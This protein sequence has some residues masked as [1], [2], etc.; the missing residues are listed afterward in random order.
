[1]PP[2]HDGPRMSTPAAISPAQVMARLRDPE[3]PEWAFLDLREVGDAAEGHPFASVRAP[4]S[5]LELVI[6]RLVPRRATPIVL[7]D[8]GDGVA[9]RAADRLVAA[10]WC[11]IAIVAG[12]IP[13]WQAAGLPL[14]KGV[15]TFSKAFGEWVQHAFD[16]PEIGPEDLAARMVGP[17]PPALID[18]RPTPEHCAFT[19]PG[20]RGCPNAELPLRLP[21]ALAPDTP[22]VVVHCAGRTRSIIGAQTLRD[23]GLPLRVL[24]LRDGTQGWELSGRARAV[25]TGRPIPLPDAAAT[26]EARTQAEAVIAR[27]GLPLIAP[28]ALSALL[29]EGQRTVYLLDPRAEDAPPPPPG[30]HRA[31]G[32]TLIQQTEQFVAVRGAIAVLWDPDL[33]RAVFAALWL[34]RMGIDARILTA[35]PPTIA[36]IPQPMPPAAVAGLDLAGLT[37][38]LARGAAVLDMRPAAAFHACHIAGARRGLRAELP[39]LGL[40]AAAPVVLIGDPDDGRARLIAADLAAAGHP[41]CGISPTGPADWAAA[42]LATAPSGEDHAPDPDVVR[43]CAGRH[44]GNLDDARAYLAWETGLLDRLAAAGLA[45]WPAP[46]YRPQTS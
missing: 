14:F 19:L 20:A 36:P 42:G 41:V 44:S 11:D 7:I 40:P 33:L 32:T 43:F 13:G 23:F 30:F 35:A 24:A 46:T 29:A 10:G 45:P 9:A 37:A 26:A 16:V 3:A 39:R 25:G 6:A 4:F 8:A 2:L 34:R 22:E 5:G 17:T 15:F 12:G 28:P 38:A 18:G 1:M 27:Q 21:A 31:P